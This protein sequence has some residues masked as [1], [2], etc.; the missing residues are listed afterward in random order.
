MDGLKNLGHLL[1]EHRK[2]IATTVLQ[3]VA[4]LPVILLPLPLFCAGLKWLQMP[5]SCGEQAMSLAWL[6]QREVLQ[7][8]TLHR[9]VVCSC[10]GMQQVSITGCLCLRVFPC[11]P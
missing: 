1:G 2:S 6:M 8:H 5:K 11:Y 7:R 3:P 10:K 9:C 4:P